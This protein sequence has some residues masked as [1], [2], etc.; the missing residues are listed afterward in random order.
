MSYKIIDNDAI[1]TIEGHLLKEENYSAYE[2]DISFIIAEHIQNIVIDLEKLETIDS[3]GISIMLKLYKNINALKGSVSFIN[4][5]N[6]VL[7]V[8]NNFKISTLLS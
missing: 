7:D 6:E 2:S 1:I 4:A 5:N 8:L 3:I